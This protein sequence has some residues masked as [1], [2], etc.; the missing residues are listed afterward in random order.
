MESARRFNIEFNHEK[1]VFS[2]RKLNILGFTVSKGMIRP[3][4]ERLRSLREMEP[5]TSSKSLKRVIG[6]F[7]Y[8]SQWIYK[9]SDKLRP[10]INNTSFPMTSE[11]ILSFES[12]KEDII[13]AALVTINDSIPVVL[14]SDAS[15]YALAAT[16][17]QNSRPIAFFTRMLSESERKFPAVEKEALA[18]VE[19]IRKWRHLLICREFQLITDQRSVS[20]MFGKPHSSKIKNDK[21]SRWRL[22]LSSY[23]YD[24]IY[25]AGRNNIV[26]DALSRPACSSANLTDLTDLKSL[27]EALCHPGVARM[28]HFVRNKNLPFSMEEIKRLTTSCTSCAKLKPQFFRKD[29]GVLI[30]ASSPF[31]RLNMDFKGPLPSKTG[32]HYILTIIDEYSRFPFA[33]VCRDMTSKTVINCLSQLFA[34]FGMCSFVHSDRGTSFLSSELRKFLHSRGIATSYSTPY[35]PR[36]NGQAERYNRTIWKTVT[37]ALESRNLPVTSWEFVLPDALHSIRSLLSTATNETPHERMFYHNRRSHSGTSIPTWLCEPGRVLMRSFNRQSKYDPLTEEV[38]LLDANT[39]YAH[40]RRDNGQETTISLRHL[41][42]CP[43][44]TDKPS[45]DS[46]EPIGT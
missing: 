10:L 13:N 45:T 28:A 18:I 14:E 17:S 11:A 7:A 20:F 9:F 4:E 15:E 6:L 34:I 19:A 16:L 8:Y 41:A 39:Q 24:I 40:V 30:K 42:P 12:L 23:K 29:K 31:E 25:R 44:L 43:V 35:N 1:S 46:S 3:D 36:G 5:P 2:V 37:L 38:E 21:I 27:H 22:E 26:P 33:F 32:N